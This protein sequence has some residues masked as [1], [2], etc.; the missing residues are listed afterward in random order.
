MSTPLRVT[1]FL[2]GLALLLGVGYGVGAAAGPIGTEDRAGTAADGHGHGPDATG[3][4]TDG[5]SAPAE[6]GAPGTGPATSAA[7]AGLQV[8]QSGYTLVLDQPVTD[9]GRRPLRFRVLGPDGEPVIGYQRQHEKDLHLIVVRRDLT[10]FQHVHPELGADG[11]WSVP[12]DLTAGAW[13]VLADFQPA[14]AGPLVLGADLLVGGRDDP[15]P[16]GEDVTTTTVDGY[17]VTLTAGTGTGPAAGAGTAVTLEISK[18]GEP[19]TDLQPYL[20]A[21]G[22]LVVLRDGD[23][24]YLHAHPEG[25]GAGP[26]VGFH[27]TF[28]SEGRYRLFLDFKHDGVVRTAAF[29][30]TVGDG[31]AAGAG[32]DTD[33]HGEEPGH[34]H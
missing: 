25:E 3:A 26:E 11:T 34:D 29:T 2:V 22:H 1:A 32:T 10:G 6:T 9:A 7:V 17:A 13:R 21:H 14:G 31:P 5:P 12:V 16:L 8:S 23:L 30:L 24:A 4:E 28:P 15:Q 33:E 20:G 27:T 19:V 18:G